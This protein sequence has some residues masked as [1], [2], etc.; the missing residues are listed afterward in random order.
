MGVQA[1]RQVVGHWKV[2]VACISETVRC[3]K[4][5]FDRDIG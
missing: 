3:K 4:L 2:C 5:I 1:G